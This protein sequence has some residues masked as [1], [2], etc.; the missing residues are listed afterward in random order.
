MG[1]LMPSQ[2]RQSLLRDQAFPKR[3]G[4]PSEFADMVCFII[5][6]PMMNGTTVRIDG[7]KKFN[8]N[9]ILIFE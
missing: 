4:Q 2:V 7:G 5:Q 6:N 3:F 1:K 8:S 9:C